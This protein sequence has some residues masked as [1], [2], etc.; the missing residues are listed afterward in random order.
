MT[1]IEGKR[2]TLQIAEMDQAESPDASPV[3]LAVGD[4]VRVGPAMV[5]LS[6][7]EGQRRVR[8][9]FVAPDDVLIL[10]SECVKH[11]GATHR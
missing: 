10:R 9:S 4:M 2:I 11:Q 1:A 7:I 6:K 3:W 5:V 8:L